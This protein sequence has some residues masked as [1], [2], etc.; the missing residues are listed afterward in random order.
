MWIHELPNEVIQQR[1]RIC[2]LLIEPIIIKDSITFLAQDYYSV[3]LSFANAIDGIAPLE[4]HMD[5]PFLFEQNGHRIHL[6][7]CQRDRQTIYITKLYKYKS[8]IMLANQLHFNGDPQ[9]LILGFIMK[10][11]ELNPI[12]E[13][14]LEFLYDTFK[15][16]IINGK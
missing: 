13:K 8:Y 6:L 16:H 12:G 3:H 1:S 10:F 2:Q 9:L 15:N 11:A 4:E 5:E 14:T 7:P